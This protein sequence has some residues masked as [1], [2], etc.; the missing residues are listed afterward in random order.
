MSA[1]QKLITKSQNLDVGKADYTVDIGKISYN[2]DARLMLPKDDLGQL[3]PLKI[4]DWAMGQVCTKLG[5][6]PKSY[7]N[8]CPEWLRADQLNYLQQNK[9][10]QVAEHNTEG[11][12]MSDKW[13]V[14]TH[15]DRVR[16]A[17]TDK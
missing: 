17:L 6:L 1:L 15:D 9:S 12:R 3:Q 5:G 14:R 13:M 4:T 8:R 10:V 2:K 7:L 11:G 16:A